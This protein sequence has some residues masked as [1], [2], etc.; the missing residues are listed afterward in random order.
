MKTPGST[1]KSYKDLR[2]WQKS[3]DLVVNVYKLTKKFPSNEQFALTSQVQRAAV[4]VSSNIADGYGRNTQKEYVHF[5]RIANGSLLELESLIT[6]AGRL[7]YIEEKECSTLEE[8]LSE[9]SRM[10]YAL[11]KRIASA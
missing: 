11:R 9:V 6:V 2:V 4:S 1:I 3:V 5:L 10:L 8:Q 7:S